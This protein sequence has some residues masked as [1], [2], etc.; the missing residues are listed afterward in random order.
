MK[1]QFLLLLSLCTASVTFCSSTENDSPFYVDP[2]FAN[3]DV[4]FMAAFCNCTNKDLECTGQ[5]EYDH[6]DTAE[7]DDLAISIKAKDCQFINCGGPDCTVSL[8]N[9]TLS[10]R[11]H[12]LT[13][14]PKL[15]LPK[16]FFIYSNPST[17]SLSLEEQPREKIS[18]FEGALARKVFGKALANMQHGGCPVTYMKKHGLVFDRDAA[19]EPYIR[20]VKKSPTIFVYYSI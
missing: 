8:L 18:I 12:T 15:V 14:I 3:P 9:G 6:G 1:K 10:N 19:G 11:I 20:K 13:L 17:G 2:S 7:L 4:K 16:K 5:L